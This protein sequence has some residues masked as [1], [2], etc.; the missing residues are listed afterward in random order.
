MKKYFSVIC[1][2]IMVFFTGNLQ[3][4]FKFGPSYTELSVH[5]GETMPGTIYL[6]NTGNNDIA[7]V[8][9]VQDFKKS[10]VNEKIS[11]KNWLN[12]KIKKIKIK[13]NSEKIIKYK[14]TAPHNF[15]GEVSAKISFVEGHNS[16]TSIN[17]KM[18]VAV[19]MISRKNSY[20]GAD[21]TAVQAEC[22]KQEIRFDFTVTNTGNIHIRPEGNI[23]I[24]SLKNRLLKQIKIPKQ[25][26]LFESGKFVLS[27]KDKFIN[28]GINQYIVKLKMALGYNAAFTL[29]KKYKIKM[30][31]NNILF[32]K[33]VK[34]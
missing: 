31:D 11:W 34:K 4:T 32:I 26:P 21:I 24:Y 30:S 19:Y 22:K 1:L 7:L 23:Y 29:E 18:S 20:L 6:E 28:K 8:C 3:G 2:L 15:G 14:V 27:V 10:R 9:F 13:A 5:P 25:Y 33:E 12:F 16:G 17:T